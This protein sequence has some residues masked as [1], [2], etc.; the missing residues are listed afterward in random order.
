MLLIV[1]CLLTYLTT[2]VDFVGILS[3]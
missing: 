2:E 1:K 3:F